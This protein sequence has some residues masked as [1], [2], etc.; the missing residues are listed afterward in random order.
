MNIINIVAKR[1]RINYLQISK[2]NLKKFITFI[3][4]RLWA[5]KFEKLIFR[6]DYTR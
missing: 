2:K 6:L 5:L 3:M 1:T 4:T